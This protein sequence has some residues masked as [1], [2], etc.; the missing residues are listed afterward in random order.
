MTGVRIS[1]PAHH[2]QF[3][4]QFGIAGSI[5]IG[6]NTIQGVSARQLA[7]VTGFAT[8]GNP[9]VA[10]NPGVPTLVQGSGQ[11]YDVAATGPA[12]KLSGGAYGVDL[13]GTQLPSGMTMSPEGVL[14]VGTAVVGNTPG[15]AFEYAEP[16]ALP[17]LTLHSVAAGTFPYMATVYPCEGVV[18]AGRAFVSPDD[19]NL[20][21]STLSTWPDGS[22]QVVVLAGESSVAASSTKQIRLRV[23]TPQGTDLTAARVAALLTNISC[24][25]GAVGSG[26]LTSFGSPERVW[27]KNPAVICA[28]Y[29]IAIG[30]EMEAIVD[31]HAFAS[32]RAFVEVVIENGKVNANATSVAAPS[33]KTYTAATVSVN[34]SVIATVSSPTAGMKAPR[35]RGYNGGPNYSGGHEAFRAWYCST[36]VGGDPQ[37][38]VTHDTVSLHAVGFFFKPW[39][40]VA[41]NLQTRYS[42]AYDTYEP[43]A[44]GRLR[45]PGMNGTGGDQEIAPYS[46][47]QADYIATGSRFARRAVLA[48]AKAA[49]SLNFLWRHTD[50]SVPTPAQSE[51]KNANQLGTWPRTTTAPAWGSEGNLPD[52]S[53]IGSL[54][55]VPFLC[56]PSPWIIE[57]VQREAQYHAVNYNSG[58][59][60]TPSG[61]HNYAQARGRAWLL[62]SYAQVILL[63]PDEDAARKTGYRAWLTRM[64]TTS[65]ARLDQPWNGFKWMYD[66]SIGEVGDHSGSRPNLQAGLFMH[67][68]CTSSIVGIV[69]PTK[70]LRAAP[71]VAQLEQ[72]AD[73]ICI[74][75]LRWINDATG[76]EYRVVPYQPTVGVRIPA[77]GEPAVADQSPHNLQTLTKS[78]M[79]GTVPNAPG[80]WLNMFPDQFNY[81][82]LNTD[83]NNTD[84]VNPNGDSFPAWYLTAIVHAVERGVPGADTAW[85]RIYGTDGTNGGIST[86]LT[87][88]A[89]LSAVS[90]WN[91]WPRNK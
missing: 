3:G 84:G 62:R 5:V 56:Q 79:S 1:K 6:A 88:R 85:T 26:S 54:G 53:H 37:L 42:E 2:F 73:D 33:T 16:G 59:G 9:N 32:N 51:G 74:F 89:N 43:W 83:F 50:G 19:P 44:T 34:G 65:K 48:T 45:V 71:D 30:A 22:A 76:Y 10:W 24:N 15:V 78:E 63:T 66:H 35:H 36:W 72:L 58:S 52:S 31:V 87:W 18:P 8:G 61:A 28:R 57:F 70:P 38:E 39:V 21:S 29:R 4:I 86:L 80:P 77:S 13:A 75:P 90:Y 91:R 20:R 7:G 17:V 27:W 55:I 23:G 60:T 64:V 14:N 40:P 82:T 67:H 49:L 69:S 12:G 41:V 46:M 11:T 68:F 47:N 25:F 81:D